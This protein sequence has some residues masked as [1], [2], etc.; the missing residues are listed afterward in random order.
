MTSPTEQEIEAAAR[1]MTECM[2]A[3]HE[4]PIEGELWENYLWTAK[5]ALTAAREVGETELRRE[6]RLMNETIAKCAVDIL[7]L[8]NQLAAERERCAQIA[9]NSITTKV[10]NLSPPDRRAV[11]IAA[12]IRAGDKT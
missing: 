8:Q 7:N 9:E 11:E 1:A 2:F 10:G 3:P 6:N 5:A 12:A 4:L